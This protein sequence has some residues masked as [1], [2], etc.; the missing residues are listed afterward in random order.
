MGIPSL[1][2][3]ANTTVIGTNTAGA[4]GNVIYIPLSG[5]LR[6][7]FSS[8]GVAY[9]NGEMLRKQGIKLDH[10][11]KPTLE[12]IKQGKD[13]LLEYAMSFL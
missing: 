10:I 3:H 4:N 6:A 1:Q 9:P 2:S 12:G 11:V 8:V 5:H 7:S 13:E